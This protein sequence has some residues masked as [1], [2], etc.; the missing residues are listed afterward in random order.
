MIRQETMKSASKTLATFE[1][2][3]DGNMKQSDGVETR[4]TRAAALIRRM[5]SEMSAK[6]ELHPRTATVG[7]KAAMRLMTGVRQRQA[8]ALDGGGGAGEG[9][10]D[11]TDE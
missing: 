1:E 10:G 6:F 3:S 5:E 2:D 7:V 9:G 8:A 4:E 11:G